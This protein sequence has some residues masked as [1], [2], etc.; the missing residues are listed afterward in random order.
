[1]IKIFADK[2]LDQDDFESIRGE[3]N[4]LDSA[5]DNFHEADADVEEY[6]YESNDYDDD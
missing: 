6:D 4:H 2:G 1:M 3:D 5:I